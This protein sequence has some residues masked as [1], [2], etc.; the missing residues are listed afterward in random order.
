MLGA[1]WACAA[2]SAST[3]S[4]VAPQPV[5]GAL[6]THGYVNSAH[7]LRRGLRAGLAHGLRFRMVGFAQRRR[8]RRVDG[9][10]GNGIDG[11]VGYGIARL[12]G[13]GIV[14][15]VGDRITGGMRD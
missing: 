5:V 14:R 13:N 9:A 10:V 12:V 8:C 3:T 6:C 7:G 15:L 4:G 2:M 11:L 1:P